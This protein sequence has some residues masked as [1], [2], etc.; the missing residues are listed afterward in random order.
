MA[1][2][3]PREELQSQFIELLQLL[4]QN[5]KAEWAQEGKPEHVHC[6]VGEEY[7]KFEVLGNDIG[8]VPP[9]FDKIAYIAGYCR[10]A[11]YFWVPVSPGWSTLI[12]LLRQ[13][14]IDD[15]RIDRFRKMTLD[16]PVRALERVAKL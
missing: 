2:Q 14:P 6:L 1:K 12:E 11:T 16:M 15:E 10:N 8:H 3:T 9:D 7:I 13:A 4:T 5:G